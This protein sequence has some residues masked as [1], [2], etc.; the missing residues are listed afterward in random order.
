MA[1]RK[2]TRKPGTRHTKAND[3]FGSSTYRIEWW[4]S[5]KASDGGH[6]FAR[7]VCVENGEETWRQSEGLHR[8]I[9]LERAIDG[10]FR[11]LWPVRRTFRT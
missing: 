5:R 3:R 11:G 6:Y 2:M 9:D 10:L 4:I 8:R 1:K 7:A